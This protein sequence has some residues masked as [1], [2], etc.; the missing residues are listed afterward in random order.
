MTTFTSPQ[1]P[2]PQ[3]QH[4]RVLASFPRAVT[5]MSPATIAKKPG[6]V[7][8][9]CRKLKRKEEQKSNDGQ[10]TKKEYPTCPT[11]DE[12]NHPGRTVLK[13]HWSPPQAQK[14]QFGYLRI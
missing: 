5:Q 10:N 8:N 13:R 12:T 6:H 11:C 7:K 4:D 3:Q 1:F 14:P 2:Q 9:D